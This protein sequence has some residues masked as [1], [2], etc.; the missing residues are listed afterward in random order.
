MQTDTF[1]NFKNEDGRFKQ[2]LC[3]DTKGLLSLFE[4]SELNIPGDEI[5][6]EAAY[7]TWNLLK[8]SLSNVHE[9]VAVIINK[10]LISPHH[11]SLPRLTAKK[12]LPNFETSLNFLHDCLDTQDWI[13]EIQDLARTDINK[14]QITLQSETTQISK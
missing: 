6:D 13:K 3:N 12:E 5:L 10:T 4:A 8:S 2:E 11:K 9:N 1:D 7:F 14:A